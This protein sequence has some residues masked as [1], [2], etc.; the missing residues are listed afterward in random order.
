[1]ATQ[2]LRCAAIKLLHPRTEKPADSQSE[3]A[4]DSTIRLPGLYSRISSFALSV[5]EMLYLVQKVSI[6]TSRL[7]PG[8]ENVEG[9]SFEGSGIAAPPGK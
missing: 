7:T 5:A 8:D 6:G 9:G 3:S 2:N 4:N 1:M